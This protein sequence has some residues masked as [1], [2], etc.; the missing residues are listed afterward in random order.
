MAFE[1]EERMVAWRRGWLV[2]SRMVEVKV[3]CRFTRPPQTTIAIRSVACKVSSVDNQAG[4]KDG[5]PA[6]RSLLSMTSMMKSMKAD[7]FSGSGLLLR[8]AVMIGTSIKRIV[9]KSLLILKA[10]RNCKKFG[11]RDD[12]PSHRGHRI[13]VELL[14]CIEKLLVI[15]ADGSSD[16]L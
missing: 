2:M 5:S 11:K 1:R 9:L 3:D 10:A 4:G 15:E 12:N 14:K 8:F 7:G 6:T 16:A 13:I